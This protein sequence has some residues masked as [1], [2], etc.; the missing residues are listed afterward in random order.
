MVSIHHTVRSW[1]S[2]LRP[3]FAVL[4]AIGFV[5][6]LSACMGPEVM[7]ATN[8]ASAA[9]KASVEYAEK[10]KPTPAEAWRAARRQYLEEQGHAGNVKAQYTLGQLY[11]VHRQSA[12]HFWMCKAANGGHPAAQ[13]Q[14][15][16]WYNEDRLDE[17]PWPYISVRP[18]NRTAYMWYEMAEK[19]GDSSGTAF[20]LQLEYGGLAEEDL[21][22]AKALSASWV[23]GSCGV[24]ASAD[25][26]KTD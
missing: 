8:V 1:R 12:A 19:N 17:D 13:L 6:N 15:G 4:A 26:E 9:L 21:E 23:P 20:R 2:R 18:D 5:L 7:I 14:L 10:N 11:H 22:A 25:T 24:L 3:A 16:H